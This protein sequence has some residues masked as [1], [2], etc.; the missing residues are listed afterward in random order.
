[1]YA[2]TVLENGI[3][4]VTESLPDV[5]SLTIGLVIDAGSKDE[6]AENNGVAHC[7]EHLLFKGTTGRP[8]GELARMIDL[9]GGQLGAFTTRDYTCLYTS[10]LDDYR[11]YALDIFGDVLLHSRFDEAS[12]R[13][14]QLVISHEI[15]A[16][17]EKPDKLAQ[18]MLK[19]AVWSQHPLGQRIYGR[20]SALQNLNREAVLDFFYRHYRADKLIV[21]A[22][23]NVEHEDFVTQVWD[24][25]WSLP[26]SSPESQS[27]PPD[28]TAAVTLR[29]RKSAHVYFALG[30]PALSYADQNRYAVYVLNNLLG[31]AMSSR[32]YQ[33]VRNERGLVYDIASEYHPYRDAGMV[34]VEGFTTPENLLPVIQLT[35]HEIIDLV[36]NEVG[37][38]ELW[39]AKERL[40]SEILL[41]AEGSNIRMSQLATQEYYFGR[42][43]PLEE[44][45]EGVRAVTAGDVLAVANEMFQPGK[46][47]L[48]G[49]GSLP[50]LARTQSEI[51]E[52]LG[53]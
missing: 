8:A 24:A 5:R 2:K 35:M 9:A 15:E 21:A 31:G 19:F 53:L 49:V 29:C 11:T 36:S 16:G 23:G 33:Q 4:V 18:E 39:R 51:E 12:L 1:M 42:H 3:K 47:A 6:S 52:L 25:L 28:F 22:A 32:L 40:R 13:H 44:I 41:S 30:A 46:I 37:E 50:D 43:L 7:I 45:V 20:K 48:S 10:V 14:E 26:G 34:V 38:E 27:T 17:E